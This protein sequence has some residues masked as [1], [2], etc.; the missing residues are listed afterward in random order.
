MWHRSDVACRL[1]LDQT[2]IH[3]AHRLYKN[4]ISM[5][6][7]LPMVVCKMKKTVVSLLSLLVCANSVALVEN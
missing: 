2:G 3:D 5:A 1:P 4:N 7:M 6:S